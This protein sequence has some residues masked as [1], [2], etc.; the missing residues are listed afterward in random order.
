M[1]IPARKFDAVIVGADRIARNG[2]VANKV[3]TVAHALAA[4]R[5]GIP[6]VVAA[7]ESTIDPDTATGE[8]IKIEERD[9]N[10]VL[11]FGGQRIAPTGSTERAI[12][13]GRSATP[14]G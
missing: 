10:E 14:A 1:A 12:D 2:D 13:P 6:F 8:D 7:P 5:A 3:G 11:C 4:K 9:P